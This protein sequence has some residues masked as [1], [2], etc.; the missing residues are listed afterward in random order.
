MRKKPQEYN[1]WHLEPGGKLRANRWLESGNTSDEL[2]R[3]LSLN[4]L[5]QQQRPE[6]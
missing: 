3:V 2:V 4:R 6:W 5:F 1:F